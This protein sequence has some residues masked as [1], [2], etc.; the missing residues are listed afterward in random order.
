MVCKKNPPKE[1]CVEPCGRPTKFTPER[2]ALIID[3]I[4]HRVPN[5]IAAESS[6]ISEVTFYDWLRTG[7]EHLY[8]NIDS[9]YSQFLVDIRKA[10]MQKIRHHSDII[11]ERPER[12]QADAWILERRYSKFYSGNALINELAERLEKLEQGITTHEEA[13]NAI[14][15]PEESA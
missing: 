15:K 6:G 11:A 3:A 9:E 13:G 7:K 10:E 12:W 8:S 1:Y 14:K 4:S 2:R 5:V